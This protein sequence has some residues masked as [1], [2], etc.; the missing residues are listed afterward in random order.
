MVTDTK[1]EKV[2]SRCDEKKDFTMFIKE[3]NIC[4]TCANSR[5]KEQYKALIVSENVI[6]SC[7]ICNQSK[8]KSCFVKNRNMCCECNN[9][10]RRIK[11][12]N[13]EEHRLKLIQRASTFKHKK[14]V[15]NQKTKQDEIGEG[16]KKCSICSQ[17]KLKCNFRHNRLKCIT[18]ER[19][20]PL[21]KFKRSVRSRIYNS[22]NRNKSM[23][24]IKY[25]GINSSDYI[26]WMLYNDDNYNL[27]NHGKEWHID[28]VIPLSRFDLNNKDEQLIAFNWRNTMPLSAK[29]NLSKNC[30]IIPSQIEQHYKRLS[31]YHKEK[32]IEMPQEYIDLFA[33]RPN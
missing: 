20:D 13:D 27:T 17:I 8:M 15:A 14:V 29:E 1:P 4:K 32:N 30:K 11:Y 18:C 26:Q 6:Q 9:Q 24:T 2:C 3:R 21:E 12:E 22:L 5:K 19:D 25:L 33:T 23:N 7:I 28:H 16:N 31:V 10:R